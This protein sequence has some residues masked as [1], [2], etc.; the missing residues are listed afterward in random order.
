MKKENQFGMNQTIQSNK[1][2]FNK[3]LVA[4]RGEIAVRIIKTI[5]KLGIKAVVVYTSD[6]SSALHIQLADEAYLLTGT[7]P[8]A[9]FLDA[10]QMISIAKK[11]GAEAIHPGYGFLS[12]NPIFAHLCKQNNIV[13]IGPSEE[14]IALMGDKVAAILAAKDAQ[15]PTIQ[16]AMGLIDEILKQRDQLVYPLLVKPAFGG[17]GKGMVHVLHPENLSD[18]LT[19]AA[20]EAKRYFSNDTILVEHYIE[21]PRHIEVQVISDHHGNILHLYERECSVQR[22]FQ[23][24]IEETPAPNLTIE[25]RNEIIADA[26][27]LA[28]HIGYTNAG[29]VEFL[30][31]KNGNHYFIEMNT[32]IQVEHP[33]TEMVTGLDIVQ[34]QIE[35]ASNLPL[36]LKQEDV[37]QSGFSIECRINAENPYDNFQPSP[38]DVFWL[39]KRDFTH[40]RIDTALKNHSKIVP[41][42]D[43]IIAKVITHESTRQSAINKMV[44]A[45]SELAIKSHHNNI[46]YLKNVLLNPSFQKGIYT[47][48]FC[49]DFSDTLLAQ[50]DKVPPA[51]YYFQIGW[52]LVRLN[53]LLKSSTTIAK[54]PIQSL[55]HLWSESEFG[56]SALLI[57][58]RSSTD[59]TISINNQD[60]YQISNIEL[61]ENSLKYRVNGQDI[62]QLFLVSKDEV[63][64][65]LDMHFVHIWEFGKRAKASKT[66]ELDMNHKRELTSPI[67]CK[68]VYLKMAQGDSVKVGDVLV[69]VE[70]MKME[71]SLKAWKD[72]VITQINYQVGD[73]VKAN[74]AILT[75]E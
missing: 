19:K 1:P 43:S 25:K 54:S 44:S 6:E 11:S 23:K 2:L 53:H 57:E 4:S 40:L 51:N 20:G 30:L 8:L 49:N 68:V 59:M 41:S 12:E 37:K 50:N 29:T 22:R 74:T 45:L 5:H 24:I 3:I 27:K 61:S 16:G 75:L 13:F 26:L 31:D 10:E 39:N 52:V 62:S 21:S 58:W 56:Q 38:G 73:A 71:N 15:I 48:T 34:L 66:A 70:A 69:V 72:G 14:H 47:T 32:R 17:G 9:S 60:V 35:I 55:I 18:A 65:C 33:I 46:D 64:L 7:D 28:N 36:K 63:I 67:P 42:F